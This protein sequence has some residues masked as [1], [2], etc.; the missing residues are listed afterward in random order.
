MYKESNVID[1]IACSQCG[2]G[3]TLNENLTC[4][5]CPSGSTSCY[6]QAT[7]STGT[8]KDISALISS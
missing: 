8:K 1:K 5:A 7:D 3:Y 2:T 6:L 4:S